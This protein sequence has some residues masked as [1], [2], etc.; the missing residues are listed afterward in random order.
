M[1]YPNN[2]FNPARGF[3]K[4]SAFLWLVS[5]KNQSLRLIWYHKW[6]S[7]PNDH[8]DI[9]ESHDNMQIDR[10]FISCSM[11]EP[12]NTLPWL[13]LRTFH[14]C[15]RFGRESWTQNFFK[16][17]ASAAKKEFGKS[18]KVGFYWNFWSL[19]GK[20]PITRVPN[21]HKMTWH[22]GRITSVIHRI[23]KAGWLF[24]S[25]CHIRDPYSDLSTCKQP[26]NILEPWES[27]LMPPSEYFRFLF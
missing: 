13:I 16:N 14:S 20:L 11:T 27:F 25:V 8:L 23:N 4:P 6:Q 24:R 10:P 26:W 18:Q 22:Q 19:Q 2:A 21:V 7:M 12:A 17:K 9:H 15:W 3:Q 5:M 1:S